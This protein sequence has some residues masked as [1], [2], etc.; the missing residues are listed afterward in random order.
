MASCQVY[1]ISGWG[2]EQPGISMGSIIFPFVSNESSWK[3]FLP[4]T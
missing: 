2:V 3:S 1:A 4:N